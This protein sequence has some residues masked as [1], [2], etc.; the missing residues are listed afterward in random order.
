MPLDLQLAK[1]LI[2]GAIFSCV[3]PVLTIAACLSSK[4]LFLNPLEKRKEAG[5]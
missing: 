3:Q 2:L 1:I 4:P 5:A